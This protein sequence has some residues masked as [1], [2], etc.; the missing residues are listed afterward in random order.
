MIEFELPYGQTFRPAVTVTKRFEGCF[1]NR[2]HSL[3]TDG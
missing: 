1:D 2:A 3:L